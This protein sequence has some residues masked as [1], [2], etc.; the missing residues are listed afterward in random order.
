[1]FCTVPAWGYG[2]RYEHGM[3]EQ[4]IKDGVQVNKKEPVSASVMANAWA[5]F[6]ND[7]FPKFV[8]LLLHTASL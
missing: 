8:H 7:P 5:L 2:I 1:M 3:F 4:R 6:A